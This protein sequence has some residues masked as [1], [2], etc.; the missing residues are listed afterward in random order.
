MTQIIKNMTAFDII[1]S[2]LRVH[3]HT[4][5]LTHRAGH[6]TTGAFSQAVSSAEEL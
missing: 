3:T 6:A 2:E 4:H 5:T 1:I